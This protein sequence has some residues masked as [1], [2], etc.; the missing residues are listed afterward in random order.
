MRRK[1]VL[2]PRNLRLKLLP[3][4]LNYLFFDDSF[5]ALTCEIHDV[6]EIFRRLFLGNK[7]SGCDTKPMVSLGH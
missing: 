6:Y 7:D 2:V 5:N 1:N 4:R 3:S